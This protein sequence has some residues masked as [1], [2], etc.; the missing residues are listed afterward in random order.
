MRFCSNKVLNAFS[1][2]VESGFE[3][4]TVFCVTMILRKIW[5][6]SFFHVMLEVIFW[7]RQYMSRMLEVIFWCR[8]YMSRMFS[9]RFPNFYWS[10]LFITQLVFTCSKSTIEIAEPCAKSVQVNNKDIRM[11][12]ISF[13]C[14]YY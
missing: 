2:E 11:T 4:F 3:V 13:W 7:C 6:R 5:N 9:H 14:L 10:F 12:S 1:E 8:Q